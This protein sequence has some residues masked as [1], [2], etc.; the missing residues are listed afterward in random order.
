MSK[1]DKVFAGTNL[2]AMDALGVS[3][4]DVAAE[5]VPTLLKAETAGLG[6]YDLDGL[7]IVE[8]S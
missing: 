1:L 2:V 3:Y 4:N 5:D 8:I 6:S 7:N